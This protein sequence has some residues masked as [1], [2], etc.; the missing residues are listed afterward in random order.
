MKF[1][2][3]T[4]NIWYK[5]LPHFSKDI[6]KWYCLKKYINLKLRLL[7]YLYDR[8]TGLIPVV[9]RHLKEWVEAFHCAQ[10]FQ[11]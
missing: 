8:G 6:K 9:G 3:C 7:S 1:V 2:C 11:Y 4:L 5:H 10:S